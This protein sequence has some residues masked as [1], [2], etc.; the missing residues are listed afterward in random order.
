MGLMKIGPAVL[1]PRTNAQ[2]SHKMFKMTSLGVVH[3]PVKGVFM[4]ANQKMEDEAH[5]P[6]EEKKMMLEEFK[7]EG[8]L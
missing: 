1:E 3:D 8:I 6:E 4:D 7:K 2:P 5:I